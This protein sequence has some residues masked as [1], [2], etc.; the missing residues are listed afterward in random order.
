M[1][2]SRLI[3]VRGMLA[4]I[5]LVMLVGCNEQPRL[6]VLVP[7][8]A[9]QTDPAIAVW[10]D[11]AWEEGIKLSFLTDSEFLALG[12]TALTQY[13]GIVLPDITHQHASDAL[14]SA[15]TS[16]A[17]AGGWLMLVY[18]FG[19][20]TPEGFYA[21]GQSR[22][23]SLAGIDYVFYDA[24]LGNIVGQSPL[25]GTSTVLR[26]LQVQPGKSMAVVPA[27]AGVTETQEQ[28]S[29]YGYGVLNYPTFVTADASGYNGTVLL[30]STSG[31]NGCETPTPPPTMTTN[32]VAAGWRNQGTGGVVFVNTPLSY[33]KGQT[34]GM[35]MH[36]FLRY[37]AASVLKM[38]RLS[39][40]PNARGGLVFNWHVDD[41]EGLD[42]VTPLD[43][44]GV[45]AKGPFSIHFTA[46]P[47]A[48]N[49]GDG[50]GMNVP[51]NTV[52]Q[53]WIKKLASLNHQVGSHGGWDH[54]IFGMN[55]NETNAN[56][57]VPGQTTTNYTFTDFLSLNKQ[58]MEA[59]L[60][61]PVTEYSAPEGNNPIWPLNWLEANGNVGYYF[62]GH[63]GLGPTRAYRPLL[64]NPAV[65]QMLNPKMWAFPVTP[66]GKYATFEEFQENGVDNADIINWYTALVNFVVKNRTSRLIYAHPPGAASYLDV[67]S[68]LFSLTDA[69]SATN[70]FRWY[71]MTDI[72]NFEA[73]RL[74]VTWNEGRLQNFHFF[75]ASHPTDLSGFSWILPKAVYALPVVIS[76][77]AEIDQSDSTNWI[78][79]AKGGTQLS[80]YSTRSQ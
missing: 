73:R 67:L 16:Y 37:F 1:R 23:S 38:P 57:L 21:F 52:A 20:L 68:S 15:L 40:H 22:L 76:G 27:A 49:F 26:E 71:T 11:A 51:A 12:D 32:G 24:L 60:G 19:A 65:S 46:G 59:V 62:L 63:T 45:W 66:F 25:A 30:A 74:Q 36:G 5:F 75:G 9:L 31:C 6:A 47:D 13:P 3:M 64:E 53:D 7:D 61:R 80:F 41:Q 55:V 42:A 79:T 78:V 72:A 10:A 17:T 43:T 50:N 18:D 70:E 2:T 28:I 69:L 39:D 34:D 29:G 77:T 44:A 35:L 33:L 58:A 54:D 8:D 56:E 14:V 48:L 4:A